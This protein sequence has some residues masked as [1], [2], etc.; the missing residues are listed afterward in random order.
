MISR[1][2]CTQASNGN[3]ST[4]VAMC[5]SEF[6]TN[7]I[8]VEFD[9]FF[10]S[11]LLKCSYCK[12]NATTSAKSKVLPASNDFCAFLEKLRNKCSTQ[13]DV[14]VSK[15]AQCTYQ[16]RWRVFGKTRTR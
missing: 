14:K 1:K 12:L 13:I 10:N 4:F 3:K 5:F 16:K 7:D 6:N 11:R 9:L 2:T 15:N 8:I